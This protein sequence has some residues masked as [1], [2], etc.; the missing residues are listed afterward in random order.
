M[1]THVPIYVKEA[2]YPEAVRRL[3]PLL[4]G[5]GAESSM[6]SET[7]AAAPDEDEDERV[8]SE[9]E[10][11]KVWRGVTDNTRK[12]LV[13]IAENH[14][15]LV[16]MAALEDSLGSF[17]A[18]QGAL[19]SLT[20]QAKKYGRNKWAFEIEEEDGRTAYRMNQRMA[21]IVL[22]LAQGT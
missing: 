21:V 19:S 18:V 5:P 7:Q 17:G 1:S 15:E 4:I 8:W 11:R 16:P 3:L 14:D 12:A 13:L 2:D 10:W 9:D 22:K 20:K 6:P